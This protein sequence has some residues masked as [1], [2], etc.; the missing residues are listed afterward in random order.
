MSENRHTA[1]PWETDLKHHDAPH[2]NI[3]ITGGRMLICRVPQDDAC[4]D[5]NPTQIANAQLICAATDLLEALEGV[6]KVADRD[7]EV[8]NKAREA[9][10]KAKGE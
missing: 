5:L 8:F 1:G 7:T 2:Q 10:K 9:I 3:K 4:H 6:V